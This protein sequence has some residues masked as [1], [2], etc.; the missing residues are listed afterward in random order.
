MVSLYPTPDFK[1]Y[2]TL[3]TTRYFSRRTA[4]VDNLVVHTTHPS[5]MIDPKLTTVQPIVVVLF[6][7]TRHG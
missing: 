1:K 5:S 4:N 2:N 3:Y 7:E 6:P